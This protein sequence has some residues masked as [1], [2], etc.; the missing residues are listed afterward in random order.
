MLQ[1]RMVPVLSALKVGDRCDRKFHC[2]FLAQNLLSLKSTMTAN[3]G[4]RAFDVIDGDYAGGIVLLCDHARN[5]LPREYAT[6]GLPQ[7]EFERH[8]AYDIGAADLTL[9]LARRLGVPAVMSRF[10]R[11][12]VDPNRGTDDPTVIMKLSDGTVIPG[13]HPISQDEAARRIERYHAP[14]HEAVAGAVSRAMDSGVAPIV[15]SIHSF[16]PAWKGVPRKWHTGFLWDADPRVTDFMIERLSRDASLIVGNNEPYVG[17]LKNDTMY[18]H[19]TRQGLPHTLLEVRNDLICDAAGVGE[20]AD[21]IAP[22][23]EEANRQ[24]DIHEVKYYGS[25]TDD[26]TA[27]GDRS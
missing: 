5:W 24:P 6:L 26:R 12:L 16:T 19:A 14:Y 20:W 23:L 27:K 25:R 17:A 21:R 10:S 3:D 22:L 1:Q 18:V 8:I 9:A 2:C 11:L 15:F 13:N 4:F 7:S